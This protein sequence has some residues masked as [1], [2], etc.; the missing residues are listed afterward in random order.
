M[1]S[2][3]HRVLVEEFGVAEQVAVWKQIQY[4]RLE[5]ARD[6]SST[7]RAEWWLG[8]GTDG[9]DQRGMSQTRSNRGIRRRSM[10]CTSSSRAI[11][12]RE[13]RRGGG[14][15]WG[16]EALASSE[17][18]LYGELGDRLAFL[19]AQPQGKSVQVPE[20]EFGQCLGDDDAELVSKGRS[21]GRVSGRVTKARNLL[22]P[23]GL[24]VDFSAYPV[25]YFS[26]GPDKRRGGL[27]WPIDQGRQTR[28]AQCKSGPAREGMHRGLPV[29]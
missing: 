20:G 21:A 28:C 14:W 10:S 8:S 29:Q 24:P 2:K 25:V 9:G 5:V 26:H 3:V 27:A 17:A 18:F 7:R 15:R 1:C 23:V 13:Q 16:P 6:R 4:A 19:N 12:L 11:W 22:V